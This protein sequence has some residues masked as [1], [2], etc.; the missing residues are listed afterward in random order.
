MLAAAQVGSGDSAAGGGGGG[1]G[2]SVSFETDPMRVSWTDMKAA[3][4][5]QSLVVGIIQKCLFLF[6]CIIPSVQKLFK[7][8][9]S[10]VFYIDQN[11]LCTLYAFHWL[12]SLMNL[13]LFVSKLFS[14]PTFLST[15]MNLCYAYRIKWRYEFNHVNS[16]IVTFCES[17]GVHTLKP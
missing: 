12:H 13:P 3:T 6:Y 11:T 4:L 2:V 10:S 7:F 16:G 1:G 5:F 14:C 15:F 17:N 8:I 9:L